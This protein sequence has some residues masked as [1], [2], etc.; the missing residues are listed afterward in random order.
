[1]T[2]K[3]QKV[4]PNHHLAFPLIRMYIQEVLAPKAQTYPPEMV[5]KIFTDE[6]LRDIR[7]KWGRRTFDSWLES[8]KKYAEQKEQESWEP[9]RNVDWLFCIQKKTGR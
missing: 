2:G 9:A 8:A 3:Y 6:R 5:P 7:D 1:M 4:G